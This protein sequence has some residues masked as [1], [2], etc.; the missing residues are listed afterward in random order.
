MV[1]RNPYEDYDPID[2]Y[3]D[4]DETGSFEFVEDE[5][6]SIPDGEGDGFD[7]KS[8]GRDVD[9]TR[10]MVK[11]RPVPRS[12]DSRVADEDI[13][14]P[15]QRLRRHNTPAQQQTHQ[16]QAPRA[17]SP[18]PRVPY[19][20]DRSQTSKPPV[21]PR[22]M[23]PRRR[24]RRHHFLRLAIFIIFIVGIYW[25]VAHP[26]DNGLAFAPQEEQTLRGALS[27][28]IPSTPAYILALGSDAREGEAYSRTDTMM[29]VRVDFWG[30]KIS[31]LSIPRDTKVE[32]EGQ[33]TQKINAA[34]AFGQAGGAVRAVSQLTGARINHVAVVHF[35]ELASLIDYLGGLTVNVPTAVYDP[36][37]TGLYLD[38]GIQTLDGMTAV[39]WARTRHGY[40]NGD[41]GRQENQRLLLTA[42]MNRV[43]SLS[44][45]ELPNLINK[46]SDLVGTDMRCYNLLPLLIRFKLQPPTIY[47]A[48]VPYTD[49]WI[50]GVSYVEVDQE[51][52][53]RIMQA[54]DE[55]RDPANA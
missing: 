28:H 22:D 31:M 5:Y 6:L 38:E 15:S 23:F 44:P 26:I 17:V 43:L 8:V 7:A 30:D 11:A 39:L 33:G 51:G 3:E 42:L 50:D 32:I 45:A 53:S 36:E 14:H 34:Y 27:L 24:R 10:T 47:S 12:G 4:E 37:Y 9:L 55:G 41:F 19:R 25:A 13:Y 29:L 54:M 52:L 46:L 2:P 49:A 16:Q 20:E 21:A 40:E 48:S 18:L 1:S 35:E